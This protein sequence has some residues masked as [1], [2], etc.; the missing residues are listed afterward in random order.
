LPVEPWPDD[1]T[2]VLYLHHE[3]SFAALLPSEL[4][5]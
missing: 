1:R 4:L 3:G 2:V 5:P